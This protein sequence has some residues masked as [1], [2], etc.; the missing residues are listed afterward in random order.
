MRVIINYNTS[1]CREDIMTIYFYHMNN[2]YSSFTNFSPHG[3]ELNGLFWPSVEHYYQAQKVADTDLFAKVYAAKNPGEAK[4]IAKSDPHKRRSDW[5]D[6]KISVMKHAVRKKFESN[7]ELMT[8]LLNTGD[9]E[10]VEDSRHDY[11]WGCGKDR[12]GLNMLGKILMEIR[13]QNR[14]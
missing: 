4:R 5:S 12:T 1:T 3:F 7:P 2:P 9:E 8:E 10:L 11:F 6:V 13:D 14:K